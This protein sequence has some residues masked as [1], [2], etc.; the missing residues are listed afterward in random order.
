MP[1]TSQGP[2]EIIWQEFKGL[3]DS[4]WSGI[5]GSFYKMTGL[6]IHSQPGSI[7][8]NQ[9]LDLDSASV[10]TAFCRVAVSVSDGSKLWFSYTTGAIWRESA[11]TYTLMYTTAPAAGAA[12]CLGAYEFNTF[13]YWA[14]QSRL[15]RIA[16]ANITTAASWTA[17]AVPNWQTFS[18]TDA[19]WHPMA[20]Q[21][22]ALY[23]G[24]GNL[25][26]SVNSSATFTASA[27]NMVAP[28]RAKTIEP[29]D[30]DI[31]IG[32]IIEE[33]VNLCFI[34]RWDT[35]QTSW[36][37]SEPVRENGINAF[38]WLGTVLLAQAGTYGKFYYYDGQKLQPYKRIPGTWSPTQR[39][40]VYPGSVAVL[41]GNAI[42]G[43]SN[44][45]GNPADQ[46]IYTFGSYSKDYAVVL[47]GPDFI[48]SQNIV[49]SIE[50][51]AIIV[52]GQDV[53]VAWRNGSN[54][55][56][57]QLNYSNK[58]GSAFIETTRIN[59][60]P[61]RLT[62]YVR[63]WANYQS[64][65]SGTSLTFLYK[66]NNDASYTSLGTGTDDTNLKQLYTED[67]LNARV[68]QLRVEFGVSVNNAPVVEQLGISKAN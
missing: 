48:I 19:D 26:S 23:I 56:V 67:D 39:A 57:D 52:D 41:R 47:S 33:S 43:L 13:I 12:G 8:V 1:N 9:R 3:S 17:N 37:A 51:G 42:F 68:V 35:V 25:I 46:G 66:K 62:D 21:N 10:V 65:P 59:T 40:E 31:V 6:D 16:V 54:F 20:T 14:T 55:G 29:F 18:A 49:A 60:D 30:I 5:K 64:L 34:V 24:D 28:L 11:G 32:T 36:Q 2:G 61:L 27:L 53:F 58:Y 22:A 7:T 15:H 63:F 45:A 38:L 50:I 44:L 4:L